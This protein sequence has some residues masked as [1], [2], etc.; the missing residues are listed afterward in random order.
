MHRSKTY[1]DKLFRALR[2][3]IKST[4]QQAI[5]TL[6][7]HIYSMKLGDDYIFN[8]ENELEGIIAYLNANH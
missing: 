6:Y 1:R 4:D 2:E 3:K 7:H 5:T 8:T